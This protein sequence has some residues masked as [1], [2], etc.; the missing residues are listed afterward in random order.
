MLKDKRV[1]VSLPDLREVIALISRFSEP[2]LIALAQ[3]D[4]LIGS[5]QP[6]NSNW[7]FKETDGG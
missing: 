4:I 1:S 7:Q 2:L 5:W 3:E 6:A